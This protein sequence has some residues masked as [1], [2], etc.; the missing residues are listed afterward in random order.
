LDGNAPLSYLFVR[1]KDVAGEGA[2][3]HTRGRVF[4]PGKLFRAFGEDLEMN[5]RLEVGAGGL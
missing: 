5:L 2:D 1:N 4:S 3:H